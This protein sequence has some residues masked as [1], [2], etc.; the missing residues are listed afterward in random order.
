M[1]FNRIILAVVLLSFACLANAQNKPLA[2]LP[3]N[4]ETKLLTYE[5]VQVVDGVEQSELYRRCLQ[6]CQTFYKNPNDVIRERDSLGGKIVCKGRFKISNPPDKKGLE[7]DA[8]LVQY[9]LTIL[10]KE[11]KYKYT[12]TDINWKQQSYYPVEKWMDVKNQYYKPEFEYYLQL[13]DSKSED[14]TKGLDK[15]MHT[16]EKPQVKEW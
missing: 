16:S 2:K 12:L 15:A 11:G 8:G 3:I 7:T 14:I 6:W 4:S 1:R 9:T 5:K 10:M 13:T